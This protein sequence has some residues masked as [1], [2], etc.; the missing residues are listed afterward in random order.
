MLVHIVL[1]TVVDIFKG[2][3]HNDHRQYKIHLNISKSS[4]GL[5]LVTLGVSDQNM[6]SS[7]LKSSK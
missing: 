4:A 2:F 6:F 5:V 1:Y 7:D 3:R